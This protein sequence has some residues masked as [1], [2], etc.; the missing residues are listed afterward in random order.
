MKKLINQI[1]FRIFF[2]RSGD[3][4]MAWMAERAIF[5]LMFT[6]SPPY[7]HVLARDMGEENKKGMWLARATC[8]FGKC[9]CGNFL[10]VYRQGQIQAHE[11]N[12]TFSD[13]F[14]HFLPFGRFF[15]LQ[16]YRL[17][18]PAKGW[19]TCRETLL[20]FL[21]QNGTTAFGLTTD[22]TN[23]LGFHL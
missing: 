9:L 23:R 21:Y 8:P 2:K 4:A 13:I 15:S 19:K 18:T 16:P 14:F 11:P 20:N 12:L 22:I 7:A 10:T 3:S 17:Q 5:S 1:I 6:V